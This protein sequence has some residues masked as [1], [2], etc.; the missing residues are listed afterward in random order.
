MNPSISRRNFLIGCGALSV[1]NTLPGLGMIGAH[2]QAAND[3]KALVCI[4]LYGG[5]DGNSLLIPAQAAEYAQYS[6]ARPN[7][8]IP[9]GQLVPL[10]Q[11]GQVRFGLNP[12]LQPLQAVWDAQRL[13]VLMNV[14]TIAQPLTRAQYQQMRNLRPINLFSHDDQ[15]NQA[16]TAVYN[17]DVNVG[18]GGLVA[19][20]VQTLNGGGLPVALNVTGNDV[21]LVGS[22]GA[23]MNI[24]SNGNFGLAGVAAGNATDQAKL[25]AMQN[26]WTMADGSSNK[27]TKAAGAQFKLGI[28]GSQALAAAATAQNTLS[29]QAF[30]NLNTGLA[31]QMR[32]V[33]KIIEARTQTGAKR[34]IFMVSMGGYDTHENQVQGQGQRLTEL[35][36]AMRAFDTA[37]GAIGAA[38]MVTAF[39]LSDFGRTLRPTNTGTDHA[40]GSH[41]FIMGAAVK[42][43]QAYGTFPTLAL[44]GP[45]DTDTSGRWIPTTSVDQ[46]AATL[47]LWFGVQAADLPAIFRNLN[48]FQVKNLGF[49]A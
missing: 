14:G 37:M 23:P 6:Q 33:A 38:N 7:I 17:A 18:W 9:Q 41:H 27:L 20:R 35:G 5:N 15:Q 28:Q 8:A 24:P 11:G 40:W 10:S 44:G 12:S 2:A 43:A 45:D 30:G 39:T 34:Q 29:D 49:M 21:F 19:D 36:A 32:R 31:N 48:N 13:A 1:A 25:T 16:Q 26:L 3:Y 47:A 22:G 42:G 4:F 46:Y